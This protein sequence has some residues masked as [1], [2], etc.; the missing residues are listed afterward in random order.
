MP[1]SQSPLCKS[2]CNFRPLSLSLPPSLPPSPHPSLSLSL[3]RMKT[4]LQSVGARK[5]LVTPPSHYDNWAL[6]ASC[7]P[8]KHIHTS[9]ACWPSFCLSHTCTDSFHSGANVTRLDGDIHS[10]QMAL[11][12]I[13]MLWT[14]TFLACVHE[15]IHHSIFLPRSRDIWLRTNSVL[16]HFFI[17]HL[18]FFVCLLSKHMQTKEISFF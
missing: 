15:S 18:T 13:G 7:K 2:V 12:P 1:V 4:H 8:R 17:T 5:Q 10:D 16:I 11:C 9:G 3:I 14:Y 6:W